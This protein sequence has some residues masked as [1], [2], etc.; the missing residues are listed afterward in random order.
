M[1]DGLRPG[2]FIRRNDV[3]RRRLKQFLI[4]VG[5]LPSALV[6][7]WEVLQ[8]DTQDPSLKRVQ[9]PVIAF[10]VVGV[11]FRLSMITNHADLL[12]QFLVVGRDNSRLA[13]RSQ[14]LSRIETE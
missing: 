2:G 5:T 11:L 3:C 13:A 7:A 6:P 4:L 10:H 14:I 12:L 8:L 9:S 1:I